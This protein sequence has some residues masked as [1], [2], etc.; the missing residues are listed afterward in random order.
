MEQLGIYVHFPFCQS[1]CF[2]CDFNSYSGLESLIPD[3]IKSLLNQIEQCP[4]TDGEILSVYFGGG[5]PTVVPVRYLAAVLAKIRQHFRL[6][7]NV[8]ITIETNPKT[9]T[10]ADLEYLR[11]VGFNRLSIGLQSSHDRLLGILGRIHSWVD[12]GETFRAARNAGFDNISADLIFGLPTQNFEE[13]DATL[14][15]LIA[16]EPEHISAYG[17]Q[18]EPGTKLAEDIK[19]GEL[20][21]VRDEVSAKMMEMAMEILPD[22]GYE[23]YEF[24]NYAKHGRRSIHNFGYWEGRDYLG[25]GAGAVETYHGIRRTTILKP[26]EYIRRSQAG[27]NLWEETETIS[28]QTALVERIMLGLRTCDGV[29]LA[30]LTMT[31]GQRERFQRRAEFLQEQGMLEIFNERVRLSK[32]AVLLGSSVT[33]DLLMTLDE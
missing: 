9:T 17:L 15:D 6:V 5:T 29:D 12:F 8:E 2:Y 7:P 14:E 27:G 21:G 11:A 16:F 32:K 25:F 13:W 24:S 33:S 20:P 4:A 18:I 23:Q 19:F 3:Y 1:K 28:A 22:C 26:K 30:E 10:Q 31:P